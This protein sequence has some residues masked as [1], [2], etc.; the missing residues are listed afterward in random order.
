MM[1]RDAPHSGMANPDFRRK[2]EDP[3][4]LI[5]YFQPL[6]KILRVGF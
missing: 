5:S 6:T 2:G 4:I 3:E 1:E